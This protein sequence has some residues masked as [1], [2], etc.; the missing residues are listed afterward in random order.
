MPRRYSTSDI[1]REKPTISKKQ[2][3]LGLNKGGEIVESPEQLRSDVKR[4][5]Y[6]LSRR[7]MCFGVIACCKRYVDE[8]RIYIHL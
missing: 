2:M 3:I 5:Y 1:S 4:I 7:Q 8:N 6:H